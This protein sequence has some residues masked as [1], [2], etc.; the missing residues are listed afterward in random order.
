M[1]NRV[2]IVLALFIVVGVVML[3]IVPPDYKSRTEDWMESAVPE[4]IPGYTLTNSTRTDPTYRTSES[5]KL[6]MEVLSPFGIVERTYRGE[7]GRT[8]QFLVI[9][10]NTRKSFHDPQVCFSA[11]NWILLEPR[12][13]N[14]DIPAMGGNVPATVMG[15]KRGGLTGLAIYYYKTPLN[16]RHSPLF[17]PID[18]TLAKLMMRKDI[19]GQFY[20]FIVSPATNPTSQTPEG[21]KE[22]EQKDLD[23]LTNFAQTCM[24]ALTKGPEGQYFAYQD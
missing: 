5:Y 11:Q 17:M 9:A 19:D 2:K 1:F 15:I 21:L 4:E 18:M 16:L 3:V 23:A 12:L 24:E 13:S 6:Q 14:I 8:Y 7:D 22:A 10:G 20:R